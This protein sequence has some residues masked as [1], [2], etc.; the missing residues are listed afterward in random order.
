MLAFL[1]SEFHINSKNLI[2]L[3][4]IFFIWVGPTELPLSKI[5]SVISDVAQHTSAHDVIL[6]LM[7][8]FFLYY[9]LT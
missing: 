2:P 1:N 4:N 8:R 9:I 3:L 5:E 6:H 7:V